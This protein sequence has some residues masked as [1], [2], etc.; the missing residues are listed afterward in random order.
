MTEPVQKG[1]L[2]SHLYIERGAALVD[3]DKFRARIGQYAESEFVR[4]A[5]WLRAEII[6]EVGVIAFPSAHTWEAGL[7]AFFRTGETVDVLNAI[8]VICAYYARQQHYN[9]S[10]A[11]KIEQWISFVRRALREENVAYT[12][13]EKGGIHPLVDKEFGRNIATAITG[14][15]LNRYDAARKA[16]EAAKAKL[17]QTPPDTKGAIRDTFEAAET[18]TKLISGS[19]KALTGAFVKAE[20]EP[21]VQKLYGKDAFATMAGARLTQSFADWVDAAHT[22]RH[23]QKSEEPVQPP[24]EL[25]VLLVSQGASFVRWLADLDRQVNSSK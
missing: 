8:T 10:A 19:G 11:H 12:I 7:N 3:S 14:L 25:A 17:E 5:M 22:Y 15:G 6:K 21:R 23:G 4:E 2:F 24:Q 18:L 9:S 20:L 1:Q 16:F 13:D